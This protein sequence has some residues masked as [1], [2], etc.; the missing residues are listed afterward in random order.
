[1]KLVAMRCA[2]VG[3][4]VQGLLFGVHGKSGSSTAGMCMVLRSSTS[5]HSRD[6]RDIIRLRTSKGS[7]PVLFL[8]GTRP[9]K[10]V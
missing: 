7:T 5:V 9:A 8:T 2:G 10:Q 3:D 4:A 1:M 6:F